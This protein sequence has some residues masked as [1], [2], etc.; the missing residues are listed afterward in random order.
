MVLRRGAF[1]AGSREAVVIVLV[2]TLT[3]APLAAQWGGYASVGVRAGT[4]LVHDVI[5]QPIDVRQSLAP[6]LAVGVTTRADGAWSGEAAVDVTF[7]SLQREEPGASADLGGLT[8]LS[9]TVA[10]RRQ[11]ATGFAARAGAG[12][13]FSQPEQ[14][15]GIF[16]AGP[17]GATPVGVLG[18]SY[19]PTAGRRYGLALDLRYDVHRFITPALRDV[20]F[21][22]SR[23]V[24]RLALAVRAGIGSA[25]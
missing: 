25:R 21:T 13:L 7:G 2:A 5:V 1:P 19:A 11:L 10:V 24:H 17:P 23:V 9:F 4:P 6:A 8:T 22:E 15:T 18:L 20:G 16:S 3:A 12:A 14:E